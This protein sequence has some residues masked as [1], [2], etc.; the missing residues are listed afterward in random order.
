MSLIAEPERH[1]IPEIA[2]I[3]N[4]SLS[5]FPQAFPLFDICHLPLPITSVELTHPGFQAV[6]VLP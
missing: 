4:I 3:F 1:N 2:P 5:T 6:T